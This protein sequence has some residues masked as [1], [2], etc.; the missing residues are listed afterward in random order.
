MTP[1][2]LSH[3][4]LPK[5]FEVIG[6]ESFA[7]L[8]AE[9]LKPTNKT[10]YVFVLGKEGKILKLELF[11]FGSETAVY[12]NEGIHKDVVCQT[13]FPDERKGLAAD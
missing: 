9:I 10:P 3:S 2:T 11:E 12:T 5:E 6:T 13:Y 4:D 1:E 8:K 7:N